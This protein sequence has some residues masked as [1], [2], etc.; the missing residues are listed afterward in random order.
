MISDLSTRDLRETEAQ[1]ERLGLGPERED[2]RLRPAL[3][4]LGGLFAQ[5]LPGRG[6]ALGDLLDEGQHFLRIALPN[7]LQQRGLGGNVGQP[8]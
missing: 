6:A 8:T 2:E 3:L 5:V 4:G 1:V 7:Y